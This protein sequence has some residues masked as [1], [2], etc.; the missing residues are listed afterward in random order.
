MRPSVRLFALVPVVV[1]IGA[2][3][4]EFALL[5]FFGVALVAVLSLLVYVGVGLL[6][7]LRLP[8]H[9]IGWLL[10]GMGTFLQLSVAASAYAWAA[11]VRSPGTL[12]LGEV[13]LTMAP[14]HVS[15][16]L[17]ERLR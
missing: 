6:L 7:T 14:A 8:R 15:L 16:W 3:V 5:D 4:V 2:V 13:Q 10:L 1:V 17:R 11:F 9:P 12:P